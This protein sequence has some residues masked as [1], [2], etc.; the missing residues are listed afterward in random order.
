MNTMKHKKN[1]GIETY[2]YMLLF[3]EKREENKNKKI[4]VCVFDIRKDT[5]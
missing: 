2:T 3:Y 4:H 1:K 5:Q